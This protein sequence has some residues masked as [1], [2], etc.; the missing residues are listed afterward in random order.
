MKLF[1]KLRKK[2]DNWSYEFLIF[3]TM[4]SVICSQNFASLW[5]KACEAEAILFFLDT[6]DGYY[7]CRYSYIPTRGVNR[8]PIFSD[9]RKSPSPIRNSVGQPIFSW[10]MFWQAISY[11]K[12]HAFLDLIGLWTTIKWPILQCAFLFVHQWLSENILHVAN[13]L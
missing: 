2:T 6:G 4:Q 13:N 5:R 12:A 3:K 9:L 10:T 7:F 1:F 11:S 8:S